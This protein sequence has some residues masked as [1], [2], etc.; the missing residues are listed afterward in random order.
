MGGCRQGW[1]TGGGDIKGDTT[2]MQ[3]PTVSE[4]SRHC[5]NPARCYCCCT[6]M[7]THLQELVTLLPDLSSMLFSLH[8]STLAQLTADT[9]GLAQKLV[10]VF[11]GG[12]R[13]ERV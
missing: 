3:N 4:R 5:S 12:G 1:W 8:P 10:G 7:H 11:L 9:A 6:P 2:P 13:K